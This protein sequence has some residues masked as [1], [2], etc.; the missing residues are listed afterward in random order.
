M[1]AYGDEAAEGLD[2]LEGLA[3]VLEGLALT[4]QTPQQGDIHAGEEMLEAEG[5]DARQDDIEEPCGRSR[6]ASHVGGQGKPDGEQD[7]LERSQENA[8]L[9]YPPLTRETSNVPAVSWIRP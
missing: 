5:Q 9:Q 4:L 8:A 3:Q 7:A 6:P 2:L 1:G